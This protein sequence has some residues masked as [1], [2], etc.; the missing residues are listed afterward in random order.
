MASASASLDALNAALA[1]SADACHVQAVASTSALRTV[2]ASADWDIAIYL[3]GVAFNPQTALKIIEEAGFDLPMIAVIGGTDEGLAWQAMRA[4]AR[5]AIESD[6]LARLPAV[7]ERE[8]RDA[9]QR[10]EHRAA[11]EMLRD[12]E[13]RFRAMATNLPGMLFHLRRE[14]NGDFRFLYVSEG[15]IKLIGRKQHELRSAARYFFD[16][17]DAGTRHDLLDALERSAQQGTLLN[18]EGQTSSRSRA[19]WINVRST[20]QRL[21]G[22]AVEWQG[23]ATNVSHSK[24]IEAALRE[25]RRQLAELSSHLEAVKEDERERIARDIHDELGSILVRLKI[26]VALMA[27]KLPAGTQPLAD[28]ARSIEDLLDQAMGTASRVARELRPGIL[29]EFGLPAAL[30]CQA[31]D[32]AQRT[33]IRCVMQCEDDAIAPDADTSLALFRIAQETLTNVVK[34]AHASLVVMRL[35]RERAN[36][37]FEVRDNGRGITEADMAKSRSFGLRGIRERVHS[38]NGEISIGAGEHGG[39]IVVLRIPEQAHAESAITDEPQGT[40]F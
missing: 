20:P 34:H 18:W 25:S 36:I 31:D 38:L 13:A 40:L 8:L 26:E 10:A 15:C 35:H 28:K 21:D 14:A 19:K 32:F 23:I 9:R 5:D 33:G 2:V 29:K 17:F 30:E 1:A 37:V 3:S 11:L 27:G 6:R 12:S 39:T 22:G 7:I 24:E 16:A 4:G